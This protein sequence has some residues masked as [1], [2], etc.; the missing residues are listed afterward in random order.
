MKT[1]FS[2]VTP[3]ELSVTRTMEVKEL[4]ACPKDVHLSVQRKTMKDLER[5][6]SCPRNVDE[7]HSYTLPMRS[8]SPT[9]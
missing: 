7:D 8:Y 1:I 5:E 9:E 4:S 6:Y 3:G 2:S